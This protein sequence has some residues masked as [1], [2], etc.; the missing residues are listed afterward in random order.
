[1]LNSCFMQ[2]VNCRYSDLRPQWLHLLRRLPLP[3]VI[4]QRY[5]HSQRWC[6]PPRSFQKQVPNPFPHPFCRWAQEKHV[7]K[8][9]KFLLTPQARTVRVGKN[10]LQI[11]TVAHVSQE[12]SVSPARRSFHAVSLCSRSRLMSW[13]LLQT[14]CQGAVLSLLFAYARQSLSTSN[15]CPGL[16][17]LSA[18]LISCWCSECWWVQWTLD[19]RCMSSQ[20]APCP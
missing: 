7:G 14:M 19:V 10:G 11:S 4:P 17:K 15:V 13:S 3:L 1:M 20:G 2:P 5:T 9:F 8:C 18:S 16:G 12:S 6:N